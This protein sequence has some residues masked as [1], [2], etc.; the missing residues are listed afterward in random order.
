MNQK[1]ILKFSGTTL[2]ITG[3]LS[4]LLLLQPLVFSSS[5]SSGSQQGI[6]GYDYRLISY[7]QAIAEIEQ[8]KNSTLEEVELL[9]RLNS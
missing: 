5:L 1:S 4:L 2:L 7:D 3:V 6:P 9:T 8:L